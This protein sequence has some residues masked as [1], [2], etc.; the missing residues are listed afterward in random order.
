M[1]FNLDTLTEEE[2]NTMHAAAQVVGE[3]MRVLHKSGSNTVA[4][5]LRDAGEFSAWE[6]IPAE[7]VYD[8]DSASQ[9]YYH[10]HA[11]SEAGD[12]IHDDEHGHFHTFIRGPGMQ[13]GVQPAPLSDF[14]MPTDKGELN[15][16]LIGIGMNQMGVPIKLFTVNRWVTGETWYKAEDVI[17]QLSHFNIDLS[18]PSWPLNLWLSHMVQLYRPQI[19]ELIRQRD[20]A[21]AAWQAKHPDVNAYE[22]RKLEVTSCLNINLLEDIEALELALK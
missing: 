4:E 13:N 20:V 16:H 15:T 10:A 18:H 11:K 17:Q 19:E 1:T 2:L 14:T 12:G 7:D 5:L 8:P 21:V 22:D 3:T 6:H 9:Y